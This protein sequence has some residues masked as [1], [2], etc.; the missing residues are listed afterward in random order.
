MKVL[1]VIN[2]LGLGGGAEHALVRMLPLM[3]DLGV[4]SEVVC[5]LPREAGLWREVAAEFPYRV[6]RSSSIIGRVGELAHLIRRSKCDLVHSTLVESNL[7]ARPAASLAGRPR[8]DS[9]VNTTYDD[10]RVARLQVDRRRLARVRTIDSWSARTFRGTHHALTESV[11]HHAITHLRVPPMSIHV[12]PRGRASWQG[13]WGSEE[14]RWLRAQ[15]GVGERPMILAIGRED[16]QKGHVDLIRS[17]SI[18]RSTRESLEPVVVIAGRSGDASDDI[19]RVVAATRQDHCVRR[20]G[21]RSDVPELLRA[22]DVFAFPSLYE[23]LGSVLIEAMEA[24]LPIVASDAPAVVETVGSAGSIFQRGSPEAL[25]NRL[26]PL[27]NFTEERL[28]MAAAAR[29]RFDENFRL[30][31]VTR[32]LVDLYG[33]CASLGT[34]T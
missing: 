1:H 16:R 13:S 30:E 24:S 25:A 11:K 19:D 26:R 15:L 28:K 34:E 31:D 12:I 32:R 20:L 21:H 27:L 17:L 5:L 14:R 18:L 33:E 8:I 3:H 2:A 29:A 9:L 4:E 10:V 22:A 7:V 6:L 23:G